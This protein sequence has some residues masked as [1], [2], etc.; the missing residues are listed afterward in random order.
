MIRNHRNLCPH[1]K[2]YAKTRG[3]TEFLKD[4]YTDIR[5]YFDYYSVSTDV[6]ERTSNLSIFIDKEGYGSCIRETE[7]PISAK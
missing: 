4:G 3:G 6:A 5:G 2:V 7:P 1:V